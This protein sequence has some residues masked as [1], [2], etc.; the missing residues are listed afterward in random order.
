MHALCDNW[1]AVLSAHENRYDVGL[2]FA[3]ITRKW[4]V[5]YAQ[6]QVARELG[7]GE[8]YP[9]PTREHIS[10]AIH[11]MGANGGEKERFLQEMDESIA[12][13]IKPLEKNMERHGV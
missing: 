8:N 3:V 11:A 4:L 10:N 2:Q 7:W 12:A 9:P 6:A 1:E 5:E 13:I